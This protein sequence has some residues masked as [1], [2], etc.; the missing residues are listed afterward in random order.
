[1]RSPPSKEHPSGLGICA[2]HLGKGYFK[3]PDLD[4]QLV[5]SCVCICYKQ[6]VRV[7]VRGQLHGGHSLLPPS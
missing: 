7:E 4:N 6:H 1:M 3:N 2:A 5:S